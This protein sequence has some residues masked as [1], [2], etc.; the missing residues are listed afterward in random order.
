MVS[1]VLKF[2]QEHILERTVVQ[3]FALVIDEPMPQ[4]LEALFEVA[5]AQ[6]RGQREYTTAA[7]KDT[8]PVRCCPPER[9][10]RNGRKQQ[11]QPQVLKMMYWKTVRQA[12]EELEEQ[13]RSMMQL[14]K[15]EH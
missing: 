9:K 5:L 7:S 1:R 15:T 6:E 2:A 10:K 4:V 14:W 13:R 8:E 11:E 12:A 3:Y